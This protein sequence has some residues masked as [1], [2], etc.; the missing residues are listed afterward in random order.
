MNKHK[1]LFADNARL[2]AR[3]R[4]RLGPQVGLLEDCQVEPPAPFWVV[5]EVH[6]DDPPAS[7][8]DGRDRERFSITQGDAS[9][10][11][12]DQSRPKLQAETRVEERLPGD[13]PRPPHDP[14]FA[15]DTEVL[16]QDDVGVEYFEQ[17]L[18][19]PLARGR[20]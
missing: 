14:R 8:R 17:C 5:E 12:V 20:Q 4:L 2:S 9:D 3:P 10:G 18:E 7:D 19:V 13:E 15:L 1:L 16:T 6:L 11:T